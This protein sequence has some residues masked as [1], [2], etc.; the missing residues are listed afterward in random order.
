MAADRFIPTYMGNA[1]GEE[2]EGDISSVHPHVHGERLSLWSFNENIAGSS[3][4]TWGTPRVESGEGTCRRFIP[5]YMGNAFSTSNRSASTSVHPHVHGERIVQ[6]TEDAINSGSSP[7]TWGTRLR[8]EGI[9]D[10]LRFIP[11]YMG[12]AR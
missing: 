4:R 6:A 12:N 1:P 11:T 7:R 10:P 9:E 3:P 8:G 2:Y 5:T